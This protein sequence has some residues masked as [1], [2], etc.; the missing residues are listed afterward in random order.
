VKRPSRKPMTLDEIDAF[1]D[2][3]GQ[4]YELWHGEPVAMTGGT[5]RHNLIALGLSRAIYPRLQPGCRVVVADVKLRLGEAMDSNATYPDVMVV[6][7]PLPGGYQTRP[8]LLAEVL[9]DSS[10]RRDRVDKHAAY[11]ALESLAAYLIL[12][13]QE[14]LVD[15]YARA[16]DWRRV[17]CE[18]QEGEIRIAALGL[19]LPLREVY[20][21]VLADLGD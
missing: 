17:R 5:L 4:R 14:V 19:F 11:T 7:D 18:G 15:V 16:E 20:A 3:M 12:S 8:V 10:T 9:S 21:D 13:Q 1:E 6:C 2:A